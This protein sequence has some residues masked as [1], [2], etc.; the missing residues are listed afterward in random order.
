M[1]EENL[2]KLGLTNGE[3]RVYIALLELGSSS[4]GPIAQKSKVAYSKIY[5]VLERLLT[6]GLVS[7][8]IKEKT[9]YFQALEPSR[10]KE[11]LDKKEQEIEESKLSLASMVPILNSLSSQ[12]KKHEAEIFTGYKGIM[13]AY[14]ILLRDIPKKGF[15]RFF[16]FYDPKYGKQIYNFYYKTGVFFRKAE[17]Y[18]K[19]NKITWKGI[20]NRKESHPG[21]P[22]K[23]PKF[24]NQKF[25]YFPVPGNI[26]MGETITLITAWSDQPIAIIIKSKEIVDNFK[27]Y[28]DTI[29]K[30]LEVR[31][32]KTNIPKEE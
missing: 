26:D 12:G 4:V 6:K 3:A 15:V 18:Y 2:Q 1:Y 31:E 25:V 30:T 8:T 9:K 11:F 24:M 20:V 16:Y 17:E 13:T 29:W 32:Q 19:K 21:Q 10:L 23:S 14:D 28:F 5:S 7:Y 27:H 22:I